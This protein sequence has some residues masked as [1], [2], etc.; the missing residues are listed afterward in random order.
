[1]S[2]WRGSQPP[3]GRR[4]WRSR[5]AN[6]SSRGR[7]SNSSNTRE[8]IS[9][10]KMEHVASISRS[11]GLEKDGDT[12][13]DHRVQEEYR[14]FIQEKLNNLLEKHPWL[15][16]ESDTQRKQ[17]V[18]AQENL[19]I[20]F[21]KLREGIS[22]SKRTDQFALEVYETSMYLCAA[23]DL[24]KQTSSIVPHLV[25]DLYNQVQTPHENLQYS[26][27]V[28]LLHHLVSVYPSQGSYEQHLD[29]IPL[30]LLPKDSEIRKWISSVAANLRTRGY[31]RCEQL[32]R[33]STVT[34]L[35]NSENDA[36]VRSSPLVI[37]SSSA[38]IFARR[39]IFTLLDALR[40]RARETSWAVIRSAYRECDANTEETKNW[41][42]RSLYLKSVVHEKSSMTPDQW[43]E[44]GIS[45]GY[46][47]KKEGAEGRWI[48][49]KVR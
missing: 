15:P 30:S 40:V 2:T 13:K 14:G 17:R 31:I 24:P 18:D 6:I 39:A 12:L 26:I 49:C 25:P 27:I 43:L 4:A 33:R 9:S 7:A 45:L 1:M 46:V 20:L 44:D 32:L 29:S 21:R 37:S 10:M 47:R 34:R 48:I 3:R 5:G 38:R 11:S 28:S 41:L 35:F 22:S 42:S 8:M 36:D 19:M 23:F 16:I